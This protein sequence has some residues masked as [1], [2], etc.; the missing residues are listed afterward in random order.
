MTVS[1]LQIAAETRVNVAT[2]SDQEAPS[3]TGLPDGGWLVAWQSAHADGSGYDILQQRF[4][5]D[6][7]A[8]S[9][10]DLVVSAA[11]ADTQQ[12]PAVTFLADGGWVVTWHSYAD[13]GSCEVYQRRY[14]ADGQP[15]T[16][17]TVV[18][19][20]T[21]E[22][23][24]AARVTALFDGGWV[25]TWQSYNQ[26]GWGPGIYQQRYNA[27]GEPVYAQDIL[28]NVVTAQE[29]IT[30]SIAALSDG[31]WVVTWASFDQDGSGFGIY[32]QRY[33]FDGQPTSETDI[34]VN[35][36]TQGSQ[37]APSV[38][39]LWGG[40]WV[41]TWTS[42]A[43]DNTGFRIYQ[44]QF[45]VFGQPA[46]P[47][48]ILVNTVSDGNETAPSVTALS[49]GGWVVA[50]QSDGGGT[51]AA[52]IHLQHF[53]FLGQP[54]GPAEMLVA[55]GFQ[56]SPQ[57]TAL[58]NGGWVVTWTVYDQD[59]SGYNVYQRQYG[60][61]DALG[62][63]AE[64]ATG[65]D[66]DDFIQVTSGGLS[67][68]DTIDGGDGT[69]TLLMIEPGTLDLTAP[70]SLA[71]VE[72]VLGSDGD[73]TIVANAARLSGINDIRAGQGNDALHLDG[74]IYDLSAHYLESIESILLQGDGEL[75]FA[76]KEYALLS[77]AAN[78]V[79]AKVVLNGSTFE[80]TELAALFRQGITTI[81]DAA[82][83]YTN[84]APDKITISSSQI[85][86]NHLPGDVV[87]TLFA[88][89]PNGGDTTF[90]FEI[91]SPTGA[92]KLDQTTRKLQV[93]DSSFFDH[94]T[95]GTL[96]VR[97]R[98]TD[99]HGAS[100]EQDLEI[101]I[102][103]VN[104]APNAL[105]L[106][107]SGNGQ[108]GAAAGMI[109]FDETAGAG[110]IGTLAATD[111]EGDA[112]TYSLS[113]DHDGLFEI[114]GNKLRVKD[115]SKLPA[116]AADIDY[117]ITVEVSDGHGNVTTQF[118]TVIVR[119]V[120]QPPP[121]PTGN[122][123]WDERKEVDTD[124]MA[125][126]ATDSDGQAITYT[127]EGGGTVSADNRFKIVDNK[128]LVNE[129]F[130]VDT[131][132]PA[133]Y[134]LVASDGALTTTGNVAITI[135]NVNRAPEAP[136]GS[137]RVDE[138]AEDGSTVMTFAAV[139][140]DGQAI[141]YAFADGG[142]VS[143]DG[144]Y[145]IV[146][147]AIVANGAVAEVM[148]DTPS[149]YALT[150]SDGALTSTGDVTITVRNVNRAPSAPS[151]AYELTEGTSEGTEV[152][153]LAATDAD[154]QSIT[155]TFEDALP[156]SNGLISA[157]GKCRI[158]GNKI[159]LNA[160]LAQVDTDTPFTY[161]VKATD[162]TASVTGAVTLTVK[163]V[164]APQNN[165]P[166]IENIADDKIVTAP[167]STTLLDVGSDAVVKDED[168]FYLAIMRHG[169]SNND[170]IGL[171]ASTL[172]TLTNGVAEGSQVLVGGQVI[173]DI[174]G[175]DRWNLEF[176]FRPGATAA[177]VQM[178]IRALTYTNG[179][180]PNDPNRNEE[181]AITIYLEDR[182]AQS[183]FANV[184]VSGS[185]NTAPT[186]PTTAVEINEGAELNAIVAT[187]DDR[188]NDNQPIGY[189]F[190]D[191]QANS[192]GLISADGRFKIVDNTI[193]VNAALEVAADT[194]LTYSV[195]ANDG[196][197]APNGTT[198][199]DVTITIRNVVPE[200]QA[201]T[202]PSGAADVNER[203]ADDHEV[204]TLNSTDTNGDAITYTF[205]TG[206]AVSADG[207]FKIVG[208]KIV[209][210]GAL[211]D[212]TADTALT[213]GIV[214]SDG[215]LSTSG[216]VTITVRNVNRAPTAPSGTA[217][218]IEGTAD[219][220]VVLTLNSTDPDGQAVTYTFSN[221]QTTSADGKFK[222]VGDKIVTNGAVADVPADTVLTYAIVASDGSSATNGNVTL[223]IKHQTPGNTLPP[224]PAATASI[225]E[226]TGANIDVV[227]LAE[228]DTDSQQIAYTFENALANSDGLISADG[229]F[230][231]V[232]NKIQV[233]ATLADVEADTTASYAVKAS[234]GIGSVTG[235]VTITV[236]NLVTE[237]A[238]QAPANLSLSANAVRELSA[239]GTKVGDLSATD[240]A[241][242]VI[243]YK[244]VLA[245]GAL[246][247]TDGRFKIGADGKSIVV[248]NGL[249][250]D[251]EQVKAYGL[252][253]RATDQGGASVEKTFTINVTDWAVETATGSAGNDVF[254]GGNGRDSLNGG[255]GDDKLTGGLGNDVLTGGAGRDTFVFTAVP[256]K[257]YNM[258]AIKDFNVR[259]DSFQLE[260]KV[261]SKLG[262]KG[263]PTNPSKL[264]AKYFKL[265]NQKQ[266]KDD[267][268]VYDSRKG[269]LYYDKDGSGAGKGV[270]IAQLK[271]GLK[272]TYADFFV[273]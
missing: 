16:A 53:D 21:D 219:D 261:F 117:P 148:A 79:D 102:T 143:A 168:P 47:T 36:E 80:Q 158:V 244:I 71:S 81:T 25:V 211:A 186:N 116:I 136:I 68:G 173:A 205:S 125:L 105:T 46:S 154:G 169:G 67:A 155:Y 255:A 12:S 246:A 8:A 266:D 11:A 112:L 144:R 267:Y 64:L 109:E 55:E 209:T 194:P 242:D 249:L 183:T 250:L 218:V 104:E 185:T 101:T 103:D 248:D 5:A 13:D 166:Q 75:T 153:T 121:A 145:K 35:A 149:T 141:T 134:N 171:A 215:S 174:T 198:T 17:P 268:L 56:E 18:N 191:A 254:V 76:D 137:G 214:A 201:P 60:A 83:T 108:D 220:H 135:K 6:G 204:L 227:T 221:G 206:G 4:N 49:D 133:T 52:G 14:D 179:F 54:T 9:P 139:D 271:V 72:A 232:G 176:H 256:N 127:F 84:A 259:D 208:D 39:G 239:S 43:P 93:A 65:D 122:V 30:P 147:N 240:A 10:A 138:R 66:A 77:R 130:E 151:G 189:T 50:W 167:G 253:L 115:P 160:T 265:A 175:A 243:T 78:G 95:N 233:N 163:N 257:R 98:V 146:G 196:S 269:I 270:E 119:D 184:T 45:D 61:P 222:I 164:P 236:K 263:T 118:F 126:A 22:P 152:M 23:Q 51:G 181:F 182:A 187:L 94:E 228:V 87:G 38:T 157:D 229:R 165:V 264:N 107:A 27:D 203:E 48:D 210:N 29:Q 223:T 226:G 235:N 272:L 100:F 200:N 111:P 159:V 110:E 42:P 82:G 28:V 31:G 140:A 41:V 24:S 90:T 188:D 197:N 195:I 91:V 273:I 216:N 247:S 69:D 37:L 156:D 62:A 1:I 178:L 89:D 19:T 192:N 199:G 245:N 180:D 85:A 129:V 212:V 202:A 224:V 40:G 172:F 33:D 92:F 251:F 124:V 106:V 59:G 231:I 258:D 132:T 20:T 44:Q 97:I 161:N 114:V 237:P 234:D 7:Q 34:L 86:E 131:D 3:V 88:E 2:A 142:A 73:D 113:T 213:Y 15:K 225:N 230:K 63:G 238:N 217:D 96:T 170:N 207:K 241:G 262:A 58:A 260:N 150:A 128:I 74:G 26:D 120:N 252:K 99:E 70:A 32:Q 193:V 162:G 57:I 123:A 190:A 177:H